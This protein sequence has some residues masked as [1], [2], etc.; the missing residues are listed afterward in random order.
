DSR[1]VAW[2]KILSSARHLAAHRGIT[3]ASPMYFRP[4]HDP[5]NAELDAVIDASEKW[6]A[7]VAA[8]GSVEGEL[9]REQFRIE[10]RLARMK[11]FP[12]RVLPVEIDGVKGLIMPLLNVEYDFDQFMTF[13]NR[14]ASALL[15][16]LDAETLP[17]PSAG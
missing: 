4:E 6:Q 14:V 15:Q 10:E 16:H 13:A 8:F 11:E 5:T 17:P 12:E 7:H 3:M 2:R 9:Y 1:F